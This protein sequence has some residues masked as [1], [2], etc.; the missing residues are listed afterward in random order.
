MFN[1]SEDNDKADDIAESIAKKIYYLRSEQRALKE[2]EIKER[3]KLREITD[4][5]DGI[6]TFRSYINNKTDWKALSEALFIKY[7]VGFADIKELTNTFTKE[8]SYE[9][10][11]FEKSY[12]G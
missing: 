9:A 7:N 12:K 11:L 2:Q 10:L 8:I 4:K 5:I 1:K 3:T 6:C